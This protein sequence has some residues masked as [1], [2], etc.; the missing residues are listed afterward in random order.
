MRI[1]IGTLTYNCKAELKRFLDSCTDFYPVIV[2]DGKWSDFDDGLSSYRSTD[3][4][5]ELAESYS[6]VILVE[7]PN[8]KEFENRNILMQTAGKFDCDIII[9]VDSDECI[10]LPNGYDAF[11]Q[12]LKRVIE[13]NPNGL[14][15]KTAF[16]SKKR[17]GVSFP[18]RIYRHPMFIRYRTKHNEFYFVNRDVRKNSKKLCPNIIIWE[19]KKYRTEEREVVMKVRNYKGIH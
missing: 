10:D 9:D 3:G 8:K 11:I 7:S 18:V 16:E 13:Q 17:G 1:A 2:I 4:T 14:G 19:T 12:S 15:F 5:L 6:N